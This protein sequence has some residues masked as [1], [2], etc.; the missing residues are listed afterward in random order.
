M[1]VNPLPA[2][3]VLASL[4]LVSFSTSIAAAQTGTTEPTGGTW[5]TQTR[6][7][8]TSTPLVVPKAAEYRIDLFTAYLRYRYLARWSGRLTPVAEMSFVPERRRTLR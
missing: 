7:E 1:R 6:T 4:V 3:A 2:L 8:G 5:A